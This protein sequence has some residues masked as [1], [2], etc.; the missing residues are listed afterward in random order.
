MLLR[1]RPIVTGNAVVTNILLSMHYFRHRKTNSLGQRVN[2]DQDNRIRITDDFVAG[3]VR[4]NEL[5]SF[6]SSAYSEKIDPVARRDFLLGA[7]RRN[8]VSKSITIATKTILG[9]I[10]GGTTLLALSVLSKRRVHR[11]SD[12]L[13]F[14]I[15]ICVAT[16]IMFVVIPLIVTIHAIESLLRDDSERSFDRTLFTNDKADNDL[17][18]LDT[19][20]DSL[21]NDMHN[22]LND[23]TANN[24]GAIDFLINTL[25]EE[26]KVILND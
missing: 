24:G 25:R 7:A 12:N 6:L 3:V 13:S 21:S 14:E 18:D 26:L 5:A 2:L 15:S 19:F 8:L 11:N 20:C 16:T 10:V 23:E 9:T 22:Y 17:D 4:D 1:S